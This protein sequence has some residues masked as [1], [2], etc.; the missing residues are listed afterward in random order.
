M[1]SGSARSANRPRSV[2]RGMLLAMDADATTGPPADNEEVPHLLDPAGGPEMT[3]EEEFEQDFGPPS[4][5]AVIATVLAAIGLDDSSEE[6]RRLVGLW[7]GD[8]GTEFAVIAAKAYP[9]SVP[10]I[11]SGI[12]DLGLFL[13]DEAWPDA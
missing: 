3:D 13:P 2:V 1:G 11:S 7:D 8:D 10:D 5:E 9:N 4:S 12:F 6:A